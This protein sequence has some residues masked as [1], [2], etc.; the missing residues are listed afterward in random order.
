MPVTGAHT[1]PNGRSDCEN[2]AKGTT[3]PV[4][5]SAIRRCETREI[6][7]LLTAAPDGGA[8]QALPCAARHEPG[9]PAHTKA[10]R[11]RGTASIL[12]IVTSSVSRNAL[13]QDRHQGRR[14]TRASLTM[15]QNPAAFLHLQH[16]CMD[17]SPPR[18]WLPA[19][20]DESVP[21]WP[22]SSP[23]A[24]G[25]RPS[26]CRILARPLARRLIRPPARS[27]VSASPA[28]RIISVLRPLS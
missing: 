6:V 4:Q 2:I 9:R 8:G 13:M 14:T 17:S 3:V 1:T 28:R 7:D 18:T 27:R 25:L 23:A 15:T 16:A 12:V 24:P 5:E 26:I 10:R 21:G 22:G 19:R 20:S 11:A